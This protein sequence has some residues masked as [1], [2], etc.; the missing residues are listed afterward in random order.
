MPGF[1]RVVSVHRLR[2][3]EHDRA[4]VQIQ[5]NVVG[6]MDAAA[7]IRA[8]RNQHRAAAGCGRRQNRLVD[9]RAVQV[10]SIADGAIAADIENRFVIRRRCNAGRTKQTETKMAK[11]RVFIFRL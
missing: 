3:A 7:Q 4:G 10:R 2:R 9:R 11:V 8:R 5:M 6:Q 1:R